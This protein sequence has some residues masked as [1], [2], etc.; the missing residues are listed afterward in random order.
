MECTGMTAIQF[1]KLFPIGTPVR[2]YPVIGGPK[3]IETKTRMAAWSLNHGSPENIGHGTPVVAV[4]GRAGGML[5]DA[6]ETIDQE[7]R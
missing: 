2:F 7:A 6:I 3:F 1:N 5:L 4:E